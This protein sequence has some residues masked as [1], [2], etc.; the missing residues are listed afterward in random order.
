M[1][2]S[3]LIVFLSLA[4][5]ALG[6]KRAVFENIAFD[7]TYSLVAFSQSFSHPG[8][9]GS[10]NC[11]YVKDPEALNQIKKDWIVRGGPSRISLEPSSINVFV[12]RN[13]YLVNSAVLIYPAQGI[14]HVGNRWYDFDMAKFRKVQKAYPVHLH[15][16]VFSFDSVVHYA[17]FRDS[18]RQLPNFLF[19]FEPS[20]NEYEGHFNITASRSQDSPIFIAHDLKKE[21]EGAFPQ[22]HVRVSEVMNDPFNLENKDKVHIQVECSKALYEQYG[23]KLGEKGPWVPATIDTRVFFRD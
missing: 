15:S 7:S 20:R 22:E 19:M 13:K 5:F 4:S 9:Q 14:V 10:D 16:R 1:K 11:F 23:S 3:T 17:F 6:Q 12:M 21:I 8:A 2:I 18:V